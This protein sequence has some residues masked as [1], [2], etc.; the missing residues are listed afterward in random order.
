M[1]IKKV[2]CNSIQKLLIV[3]FISLFSTTIVQAQTSIG[4]PNNNG[5]ID[6]VDALVVAQ[7]YVGLTPDPFDSISADVNCSESVDIV[8]ALLIAQYYV[9]LIAEFTQCGLT[10]SPT[11]DPGA[12]NYTALIE[13]WAKEQRIEL[14]GY[15]LKQIESDEVNQ[16]LPGYIFYII[17]LRQYPV[18]YG[19]PD[20]QLGTQCIVAINKDLEIEKIPDEDALQVF[21]KAHQIEIN[22]E[23]DCVLGIKAWLN[24]SQEYKNDGYYTFL[25]S[26]DD[27]IV[28]ELFGDVV[29]WGVEGISRVVSG[30]EGVITAN[31]IIDLFGS[32]V[33]VTEEYELIEGVRPICQSTKLLDKDPIVR[34]MAE[35]DLLAMGF[36]AKEYLFNQRAASSPK[37]Q[38]AIDALW[39]RIVKEEEKRARIID[40]LSKKK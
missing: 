29:T 31:I 26:D 19:P 27:I 21:Y 9:G 25:I 23:V 40:L 36:S 13:D 3:V 18:A 33:N 8:D 1:N 35:K 22:T 11:L 39:E 7:Y 10:P 30:G 14:T 28:T 17:Y 2:S 6:I 37:L 12:V 4:D 38:K 16:V 20:E 24:L 15:V 32:L 5:S 34:K